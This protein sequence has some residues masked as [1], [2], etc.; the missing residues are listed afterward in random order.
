MNNYNNG[1]TGTVL[2]VNMGGRVHDK[3]ISYSGKRDIESLRSRG[4]LYLGIDIGST[5]S[6]VVALDDNDE[7]V[8]FD[9]QRTKG[10]P[11][12]TV[13]MQL[14]QLLKFTGQGNIVRA[15][16]TGSAGRFLAGMNR[17]ETP[18]RPSGRVD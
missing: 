18:S 10:R 17:F 5:S 12:E 9:Y 13:R 8:F 6:D 3:R 14:E 7:L 1:L 15:S 11:I 16:A 2:D 4:R